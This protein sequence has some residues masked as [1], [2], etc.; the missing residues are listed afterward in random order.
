MLSPW[1]NSGEKGG[2]G[3]AKAEVIESKATAQESAAA[4]NF[5][6]ALG[7]SF[8]S[9]N[10]LG[11]RIDQARR[12]ADPVALANAANELAVAEQV[13]GKKATLTSD[14]LLKEAGALA[15][16]RFDPSELKAV[17]LLAHSN[18]ALAKELSTAAAKAEKA[19]KER[20]AAS[21]EGGK[22]RGIMGTLHADSRV[23][24]TIFVYVDGR[25]VGSMGPY[26]DI[27]PYIGQT[28]WETTFL[29]AHSNDG[30]TWNRQVSSAVNNYHW[31][32]MP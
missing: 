5:A 28:A 29:S 15:K 9:L 25:F 12:Q 23:N 21:K 26:G 11:S 14:A 31:I 18:E 27:Y 1:A 13:S 24:A 2:G 19:E 7:L 16:M 10:T 32:L 6:K 4:T 3:K 22:T 8:E 17:G 20:I 30:R